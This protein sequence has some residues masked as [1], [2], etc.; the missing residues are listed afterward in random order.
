MLQTSRAFL[1]FA[2]QRRAW[3]EIDVRLQRTNVGHY[4]LNLRRF[5]N[6]LERRHQRITVLNP[7][8][9]RFVRHLIVIYRKRSAFADAL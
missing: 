3:R 1:F 9:Q 7:R 6:F 4:I 8:S 5:Q 2:R